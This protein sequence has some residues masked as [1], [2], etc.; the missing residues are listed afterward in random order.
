MG[1]TTVEQNKNEYTVINRLTYPEAIN[2]RELRAIAEGVIEGLI[3]VT[4]EQSKKGVLMKSTVEDRMT[5][6]SYFNSVV[7]KKMFLDTLIQLVAV[8]KECEK[9]LMNVN[10]LML[11]WDSVFL[12]P[13]TKKV[14]CL[15]WPIVNNQHTIVPAE[16]FRD[17]PFR[18]VFSKHEDPEYVAAYIGYFRCQAPFSINHFEKFI[19][20]LMGK[21]VENKSHIPSGSTGP[22]PQVPR[23]DEAK[24]NTGNVAYN[25]LGNRGLIEKAPIS[26]TTVLGMVEVDGGTTVLGADLFEE[27]A[28]PY[29][30][31]EKTQ[32][33]IRINQPSFRIGKERNDCDYMVADNNAVS[34][35][36]ADIIT[37][38][39][40]YYI[41][42]N[43][44]TNKTFVDGRVI[45]VEKEIEIFSG[46]K[47]RLANE[48]F[49]FYI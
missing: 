13:R 40:R 34:R 10:N 44:S 19:L 39:R 49:V 14:T 46:T 20:G 36:H 4:T 25:P 16:F 21:I 23:V 9:K 35:N 27:P 26:E 17:L 2:E 28:F 8:V 22:E 15:F 31:R 43:C 30:V 38:N 33:T 32:E 5:L 24:G 3:P 41:V 42:D 48:D 29:L 6:Q 7:N 1:K 18:V 47:L 45:P 11:N 12:D 37:R